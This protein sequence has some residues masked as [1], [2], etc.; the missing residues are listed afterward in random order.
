MPGIIDYKKGVLKYA[1]T[2]RKWVNLPLASRFSSRYNVPTI[3]ENDVNTITLSESLVGAGRGHSNLVSILIESGIGAGIILNGQL[4]RGETSHFGEIGFFEIGD[5]ISNIYKLKN[6][7][8]HQR[9]F[10]EILSE[11][12]LFNALKKKLRSD[13]SVTKEELDRLTL[14]EMLVLGD[15]GNQSIQ[16]IIDEYTYPL[17]IAC[18]NLIKSMD[19]GIL[20]ISG[21]VIEKSNYL[22][23]NVLQ[24]IEKSMINVPFGPSKIAI[25]ELKERAG[26]T[27]A[28]VMALQTIFEHPV[29][30]MQN[31]ENQF[32]DIKV[33]YN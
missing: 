20:I 22:Y 8:D 28:I 13:S 10:G 32:Y 9:F 5:Y 15:N 1:V 16:E 25:G 29:T 31:I 7:Y 24:L 11:V 17:A 27:G 18:I 6:L 3:I 23:K 14:K 19:P 4:V 2:L 26:V 33:D 21:L 12:N 30:K